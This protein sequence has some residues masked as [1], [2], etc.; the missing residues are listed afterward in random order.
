VLF[1]H[2]R[3]G[4]LAELQRRRRRS[5]NGRV[6]RS[7]HHMSNDRHRPVYPTTQHVQ[8]VTRGKQNVPHLG[9]PRIWLTSGKG[10]EAYK[11]TGKLTGCRAIITGA[12]SG[13]GR[14]VA[15][16]FT[17]EGA[18]VSQSVKACRTVPCFDRTPVHRIREGLAGTCSLR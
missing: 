8:L 1:V 17:H 3:G 7:R 18:D 12:D 13:I 10:E 9:S 14:A 16:A 2:G 11:G 5:G 6:S 15:I 4:H